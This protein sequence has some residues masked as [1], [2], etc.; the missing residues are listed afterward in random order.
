MSAS[1]ARARVAALV[2]VLVMP[3]AARA[4]LSPGELSQAHAALE[5]SA[6]CL[7]C[8]AP[9]RGV[10]AEKCLDCHG[11][12]RARVAARQGLH[13][14]PGYERCETC[15]IE[16]HGRDFDLVYWGDPADGGRQA[17]DHRQ[18][19]WPLVG[20]HRRLDCRECHR[21]E[22]LVDRPAL[23]RGNADPAT[24]FLGLSTACLACHRDEHRGQLASA[25]TDCHSMTAWR[26]AP[27]FDHATA[28][29][30]LTGRHRE[31]A[32][33]GCHP[34]ETTPR[35]GGDAAFLRFRPLAHETCADCHRDPHG[36]RLGAACA[37]CHVTSSFAEVEAA[38]F[39]HSRTG[40]P[41]TG[42]HRQ[43]A[44]RACHAD[45]PVVG[46]GTRR[47]AH[48]TCADCHRD[49]H[50]GRL[51]AVCASCHTTAGWR[52]GSTPAAFDHDLTGFPL[53]GRHRDVACRD[54]HGSGPATAEL[55]SETCADCHRD[56]H[57]GALRDRVDGGACES[58]HTASGFRPS[59][60]S[61]AEHQATRFPL[62][63]A[64]LAVPCDTCHALA[65]APVAPVAAH[66][67][68]GRGRRAA[69]HLEFPADLA[70]SSCHR[71]PHGGETSRLELACGDCH[72]VESWRGAVAGSVAASFDHGA[73][74]GYPLENAHATA[75]CAACH[76]TD[77]GVRFAATP[78]DCAACHR[79]PH[80]RRDDV[81]GSGAA[82]VCA[83]CH[84]TRS[85]AVAPD[86]F[87]HALT[88]FGLEGAHAAVA[89]V[90]CHRPQR[91]DDGKVV[92][93]SPLPTTCEGCHGGA[94][95]ALAGSSVSDRR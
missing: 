69:F 50:G 23:V 95:P 25:C 91:R 3:V 37:S 78:T 72:G 81:L 16:H 76:R 88:G 13:A 34:T 47:L 82:F 1:A 39:D 45:G 44:C 8:H 30:A 85:F 10:A 57:R 54:C 73:V 17:F 66:A 74:T 70:C 52:G 2:V 79:D 84:T 48:G 62:R 92:P 14:R 89:C 83:G 68:A 55:A 35:V 27:G 18:A 32:C 90:D 9:G 7:D 38:S 71:D 53:R 41:L 94:S 15:H 77:A 64:H 28:G 87:D 6:H 86:D 56:P 60:F 65:A 42:R 5:G 21:P 11:A 61:V 24:T 22:R 20:A 33:T 43:L 46:V 93:F 36:G 75:A 59:T 31:V 58:C 63:G 26:P 12:L 40:F 49:P 51:G 67:Q 19:G 29:F 4:Q 80:P